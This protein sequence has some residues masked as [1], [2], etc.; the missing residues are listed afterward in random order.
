MRRLPFDLPPEGPR[1]GGGGSLF[2]LICLV[3]GLF[4]LAW[5]VAGMVFQ[6]RA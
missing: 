6:V 3:A 4:A 5:W 1:H 2:G